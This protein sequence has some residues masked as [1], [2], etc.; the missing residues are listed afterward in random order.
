MMVRYEIPCDRVV[1]FD[2]HSGVIKWVNWGKKYV[3][4][5]S[6]FPRASVN[7][8][9]FKLWDVYHVITLVSPPLLT[10]SRGR[11]SFPSVDTL[12]FDLL[13]AF[14]CYM[15]TRAGN[16]GENCQT[17]T[18][19]QVLKAWGAGGGV[20]RPVSRGCFCKWLGH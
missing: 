19:N 1:K 12:H 20:G 3:S 17:E 16:Q 11:L 2:V 7:L 18:G 5:S 6:V 14:S 4:S 15:L 10:V 9:I 13:F 8:L